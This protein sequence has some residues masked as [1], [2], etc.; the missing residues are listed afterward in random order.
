M[1]RL[2]PRIGSLFVVIMALLSLALAA[3]SAPS[4]SVGTSSPGT[5]STSTST[6]TSTSTSTSSPCATT[7][8][9]SALAWAD[10]QQVFGL[11]PQ[12]STTPAQVSNFT[13]PL[14][15]PDEGAVGNSPFASYI[16]VAPDARHLA[17]AI[18]QI[19]P[20]VAE[21][22]PYIVDL[23]TH[24][25]TRVPLAQPIKAASSQFPARIFAWADTHTLVLFTGQQAETYDL[26]TNAL[27][28]LSGTTGAVEGVVRCS[29]VFY[30]TYP[31][32]NAQ[33]HPIVSE[34]VNQYSLTSHAA[35]NAPLNIGSAGT[36]GGAEGEVL[37][38]GWDAS[39]DGTKV[40]Y[41][42]LGL[43]GG[44][45][46]VTVTGSHWAV[47]NATGG[48]ASAILP[49]AT[50]NSPAFMS[51]SPDGT[52]VA[53]T[54]ANPSPNVVSGPLSGGPTRFYDSPAAYTYPAWRADSRAFYAG[55]GSDFMGPSVLGLYA[56]GSSAHA[57]GTTPYTS[58]NFP[59]SLP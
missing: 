50:S 12:S 4:T 23:A 53:V 26:N 42:G 41:Q 54:N 36:W 48:P 39:P 34:Y 7:P 32:L 15:I 10:G 2:R 40:A 18:T 17:V 8:T 56:L 22:N 59:A 46:G 29:T 44:S 33:T 45:G 19:V 38:G 37:Y 43:T 28:P 3:C 57:T 16:A 21:Y 58:A 11:L 47:V 13:Y 5:T 30:L 6:G 52:Q 31:G 51:I 49:V 24:A 14:G 20:F 25:V 55:V 27:T 1:A 9:G 35:V